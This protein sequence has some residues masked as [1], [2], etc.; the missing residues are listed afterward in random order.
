MPETA[1]PVSSVPGVRAQVCVS[2]ARDPKYDTMQI[3]LEV[4]TETQQ[5]LLFL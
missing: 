4:E 2:G 5:L 1:Q 3:S